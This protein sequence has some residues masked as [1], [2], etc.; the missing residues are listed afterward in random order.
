MISGAY[1][2]FSSP[3]PLVIHSMISGVLMN[4][5]QFLQRAFLASSTGM[6]NMFALACQ[7]L[8]DGRFG[9]IGP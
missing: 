1:E 7:N 4:A 3:K 8:V 2:P 5:A 9:S 6:W